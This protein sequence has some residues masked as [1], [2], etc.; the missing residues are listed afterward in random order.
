T[1]TEKINQYVREDN[2]LLEEYKKM[3]ISTDNEDI[4]VR[5]EH[6][7]EEFRKVRE[8]ILSLDLSN[9]AIRREAIKIQESNDESYREI[10][11]SLQQLQEIN[12][13]HARDSR[14]HTLDL[15]HRS[16]RETII[17]IVVT[18][19]LAGMMS[20]FIVKSITSP[21]ELLNKLL[22]NVANRKLTTDA[23][24]DYGAEFGQ[25]FQAFNYM[26]GNLRGII[27][28]VV[29]S[30]NVIKEATEN[31]VNKNEQT[32]MA[33]GDIMQMVADLSNEMTQQSLNLQESSKAMNEMAIGVQHIVESST[34]VTEMSMTT[35]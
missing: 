15:F 4:I 2:K 29:T 7:I 21:I 17:V 32:Q 23:P 27:G 13:E 20:I 9:E 26:N 16:V 1:Y 5:L 28:N 35:S 30:S 12:T 11:T 18:I 25:M 6:N 10:I 14:N 33:M 22:S 19:I 24:T 8:H 34:V 31:V 3:D